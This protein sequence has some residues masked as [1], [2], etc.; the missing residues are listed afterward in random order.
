MLSNSQKLA[1]QIKKNSQKLPLLKNE[2]G[3][4]TENHN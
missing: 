3:M 1:V 4:K 2:Q